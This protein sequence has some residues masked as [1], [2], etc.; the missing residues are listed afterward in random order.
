MVP[1]QEMARAA[2]FYDYVDQL[3]HP[4][5]AEIRIFRAHGQSPARN[6]NI[7][8][9]HAINNGCT[10]LFFIDDDCLCPADTLLKL[11]A[12]DVDVVTG[13]YLM[14]NH[15][16]RPIIFDEALND[17][18]CIWHDIANDKPELIPIKAAGMGCLLV[19]VDVLK[20]IAEKHKYWVTLGELEADTWCDDLSFFKRIREAGYPIYCDLHAPVGHIAKAIIWPNMIDGKWCFTYDTE[21]VGTVSAPM[22]NVRAPKDARTPVTMKAP[23]D[24]RPTWRSG[25][26]Q[27]Q[28]T[29]ACE[30]AC[31]GCTQGSNLAGRPVVMSLANVEKALKSLQ[32]YY[33]VVGIFGGNPTLHPD[34]PE[35]CELVRKYIPLEQAGLWSNNL[36]GYGDIV[37]RTFNPAYSNL[38]V[39]TDR[40]AYDE[41]VNTFPGAN[42]IGMKDSRHS[43]PFVALKDM[44]DM[45]D[46]ERWKLIGNCDIN[47][48]WSAMIGQ[49]RGELR[50]WFCELAGAQSMLHES[51]PSYPDT[52]IPVTDDWWQL[53]IS[54]FEHQ[55]HKH[56]MECGIPLRAKGSLALGGKVEYVSETHKEIYKLKRPG[57]KIIQIV[58]NRNDLN[59][60]VDRAT[61][62]I[63]NGILVAD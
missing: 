4:E 39:H 14:R 27:V 15:P 1:T 12:H 10:H 50:A 19:K 20:K 11:V 28:I 26:I 22:V 58:R 35:V 49:F 45:T 24:T 9:Q 16:H 7:A 55:I 54:H 63:N 59:G 8:I 29:R 43:P 3:Q 32:S 57:S 47:Q 52:G 5:G 46:D 34:F 31:C 2:V 40:K 60:I 42:P 51:D 33:G 21:G 48:Y 23:G 36:N 38:N 25:V 17:G 13:L 37:S 30:L 44:E 6:R 62:Y 56:C 41:M 61:D 18:R 53:P